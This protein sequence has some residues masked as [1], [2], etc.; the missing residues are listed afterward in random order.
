M[1]TFFLTNTWRLDWCSIDKKRKTNMRGY[2]LFKTQFVFA[3]YR[4]STIQVIVLIPGK[5][6][7]RFNCGASKSLCFCF[8]KRGVSHHYFFWLWGSCSRQYTSRLCFVDL[9]LCRD[10]FM[11]MLIF[12]SL[13]YL[14]IYFESKLLFVSNKYQKDS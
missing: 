3:F 6:K 13:Y 5:K 4:T 8:R 11:V 14:D 2:E 7:H 10:T 9:A 12:M 1:V